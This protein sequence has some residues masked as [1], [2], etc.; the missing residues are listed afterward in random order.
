MHKH[1]PI[2]RNRYLYFAGMV[3]A[4]LLGIGSR[5][6]P[7]ILPEFLY[8]YTGDTMWA[9][10]FF[11]LVG[12]LVP[13]LSPLLSAGITLLFSFLIE[14][15][16]LYHAPWIDALRATT[17]G[18][19]LLGY[20]FVFSDLICYSVGVGIGLLVEVLFLYKWHHPFREMKN[21]SPNS[22]VKFPDE[23]PL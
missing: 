14:V 20:D 21:V 10:Y 16:Q 22:N 6:L 9:L 7:G 23:E 8:L 19:L 1:L 15:S 12:F 11:L 17:L 3:L 13:S 18:G 5:K 2:H 4:T